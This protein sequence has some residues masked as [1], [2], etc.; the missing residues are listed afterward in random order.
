MNEQMNEIDYI[1]ENFNFN[2][3]FLFFELFLTFF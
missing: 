1:F 2:L 3:N